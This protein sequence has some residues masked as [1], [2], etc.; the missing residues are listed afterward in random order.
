[1]TKIFEESLQREEP[2]ASVRKVESL[3]K[4]ASV[5]WKELKGRTASSGSLS[6]FASDDFFANDGRKDA[7]GLIMRMKDAGNR[8][9]STSRIGTQEHFQQLLAIAR[10]VRAKRK[11]V[12]PKSYPKCVLDPSRGLDELSSLGRDAG[13]RSRSRSSARTDRDSSRSRSP[14]L[15]CNPEDLGSRVK[16]L[17]LLM[18]PRDCLRCI[19]TLNA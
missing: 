3:K 2:N 8:P 9:T 11:G 10:E 13:S 18:P 4:A 7:E 12:S 15:D 19:E 17:E 6:N 1:M 14:S 16:R 5:L